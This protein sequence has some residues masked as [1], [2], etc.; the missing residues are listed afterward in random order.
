MKKLLIIRSVSFQQLDLNL[1]ELKKAFPEYTFCLLTH[2][3]GVE[4]AKKYKDIDC[5]YTYDYKGSFQKKN[6]V[7]ELEQ[8][9]FA[10]VIIPVTNLS[11][12]GF[13]N[14]LQ[15]GMSL[16]AKEY[17][18][19]NLVAELTKLT[20]ATLALRKLRHWLSCLMAGILSIP[21]VVIFAIC[22]CFHGKKLRKPAVLKK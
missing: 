6:K 22:W 16:R 12:S 20:K 13:D 21:C 7:P 18:M 4:L 19:S 2:P 17:Y 5:V 1:P 8:E 10:V 15:Y 14:V 3:H 11:G 9:E